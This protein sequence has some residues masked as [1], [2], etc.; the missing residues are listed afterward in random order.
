MAA[1]TIEQMQEAFTKLMDIQSQ[2]LGAMK[3]GKEESSSAG[4]GDN[5]KEVL[6]GKGLEMMDKFSDGEA[7][8]NEWSEDFRTVVQTKSGAAG[9]ALIYMKTAGKTEKEVMSWEKVVESMSG[10]RRRM[11]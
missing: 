6:F 2:L 7:G 5:K 4:G 1:I 11:S 8:W 10:R 9:E 3:A